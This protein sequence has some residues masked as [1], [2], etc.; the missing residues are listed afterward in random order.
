MADGS[1]KLSTAQRLASQQQGNEEDSANLFVEST[2]HGPCAGCVDC[3]QTESTAKRGRLNNFGDVNITYKWEQSILDA[4]ITVYL[5]EEQANHLVVIIT[6]TE[7]TIQ[8]SGGKT[9]VIALHKAVEELKSHVQLKNLGSSTVLY[10]TVVKQKQQFWDRL[11]ATPE[12]RVS[13]HSKH[14]S[15]F[16]HG[17]QS[18]SHDVEASVSNR[19]I[20][21]DKPAMDDTSTAVCVC[22]EQ[23]MDCDPDI[24][25]KEEEPVYKLDH[26]KND[27]FER[28]L[29]LTLQ[30]YVKQVNKD[31]VELLF[32]KQGFILKFHTTDPKFLQ[33]HEGTTKESTFIWPVTTRKEI[34]PDECKF[35]VK[36]NVIEILLQKTSPERWTSLEAPTRKEILDSSKSDTWMPISKSS[37]SATVPDGANASV[38]E[39]TGAK[40][41]ADTKTSS[42]VIFDDLSDIDINDHGSRFKVRA[43]AGG[44]LQADEPEG[45]SGSLFE[46]NVKVRSSASQDWNKP[47]AKV[48]PLYSQTVVTENVVSRGYAGLANLGN[49]CFMNCVLQVLANTREFRDYFLDGRFQREINE[50][51]LLGMRGHLANTFGILMRWLWSCK[52][53][54]W[55]PRRLKELISKKNAQFF[56]YAQHDAHE[57]LAFLL[58]GLHED[59]NRIRQKPYT[60]TIDSDGRP[61]EMVAAEAWAQYKRRND[62]VV[63]DLFQ[64]QYKSKL[65]CPKCGKVSIT[66]DPF[67]YLSV[68]L[69]KKKKTV[70]VTF[71]W[72]ESYKRPV[73]YHIQ[74]PQDST[75]EKLHE[76]LSKRT[77]VQTSDI[78]VFEA[79]RGRIKKFFFSGS[80]LDSIEQ[81]D[82]I[83]ACEILSEELAGETVLEIIVMQRTLHPID[84][85]IRCAFCHKPRCEGTLLKRCTNCYK[86]G[87][88]DQTCQRNH[89]S[90]GHKAQ[91]NPTPDPVGCPFIISL[92]LS[93]A[94]YGNLVKHMEAFSRFSVDVFQPPVKP[95]EGGSKGSS[96]FSS[97]TLNNSL[98][99]SS[100]S[101]NSLD[102][103]SSTSSTCTLTGNQSDHLEV[104]DDP[105][106]STCADQ[107]DLETT[108]LSSGSSGMLSAGTSTSLASASLDCQPSAG[109]AAGAS[110]PDSTDSGFESIDLMKSPEKVVPTS[111]VMGVQVAEADREKATPTFYIKPV[112]LEGAGIKGADRLDD[113]GE[114]PLELTNRRILSMDWR[115][116]EKQ[117]FYV[118]VQSKE[119]EADEANDLNNMAASCNNKPSLRQCLELFT[120]PEILSPEEAWYCPSCKKHVEASKQMTIW[121]LPYILIIQLKRFSFQN[122]L[123]RA[124]VKKHIEFPTR[125]LNMSE[126]CVGLRPDEPL[127]VYDLY[128]VVNHHGLLIGGHY[129]SYVKCFADSITGSDEIGWRLCDDSRVSAVACEKSVVTPDAYLL[130]YRRR[131]QQ[132]VIGSPCHI[133]DMEVNGH[134]SLQADHNIID[135][136][137]VDAING[138]MPASQYTSTTDVDS[139]NKL[140]KNLKRTKLLD[141][142]NLNTGR[143]SWEDQENDY[144][145][146]ACVPGARNANIGRAESENMSEQ[147]IARGRGF[148]GTSPTPVISQL[149]NQAQCSLMNSEQELEEDVAEKGDK[150]K[151]FLGIDL[152]KDT[153]FNDDDDCDDGEGRNLMVDM[154]S[155]LSYTDMEA[156][157]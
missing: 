120:E 19:H 78:R 64:G 112:T 62:S 81:K 51:N 41:H 65:V 143:V 128:G 123:L 114:Q 125:G 84:Y 135:P 37:Q 46:G 15:V 98:S 77:H 153:D 152:Q 154:N 109:E 122:F 103:L 71:M 5:S 14:V 50:D 73:R 53:Q 18:N 155:D 13:S 121:R 40:E 140:L 113:R 24:M 57:F 132:V 33:L 87:Y 32:S 151:D 29:V 90:S 141:N 23:S 63:V 75:V 157:D 133:E 7:V 89:W 9:F 68:P 88:C 20:P 127:P 22:E 6:S 137:S 8:L 102:S 146:P 104:C 47:T 42:D 66:F 142:E 107:S 83:I 119:L 39:S 43:T 99:Q 131:G 80:K 52:K 108:V 44:C 1:S 54:Y 129:T 58:D 69:P 12:K 76:E 149:Q 100:S 130:F 85:P 45:A 144:D 95:S 49:T 148:W 138:N 147:K 92:P 11:E 17:I 60:E 150:E 56:G 4:T 110:W 156:V 115:N 124:K 35:K 34:V 2:L 30:V 10:I 48:R 25:E 118:L 74:V 31:N 79:F 70:T 93:R 72:K 82:T 16:H 116:N 106:E 3:D 55:E 38:N 101:L 86:V 134:C 67:L 117:P 126:Y 61:D 105:E 139:A 21:V 91:C 96:S 59:L 97:S 27:F 94:T 145:Q 28:G 36:P 136:T 111:P 26:L